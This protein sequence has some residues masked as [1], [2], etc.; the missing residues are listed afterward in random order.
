MDWSEDDFLEGGLEP[1]LFSVP[2]SMLLKFMRLAAERRD[3]GERVSPHAIILE[4]LREYLNRRPY[5]PL[6][7][8]QG[9][10]SQLRLPP[11][12]PLGRQVCL[13]CG[14]AWGRTGLLCS[15]YSGS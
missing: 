15:G 3:G 5:V 6:D 14:A 4:A 8:C 1:E 10:P 7:Q 11:P 13:A 12:D 2:R 9:C